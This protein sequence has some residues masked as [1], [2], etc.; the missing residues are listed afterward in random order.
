MVRVLGKEKTWKGMVNGVVNSK[1][2]W[3]GFGR[4]G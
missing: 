2:W 4:V 3:W 1:S